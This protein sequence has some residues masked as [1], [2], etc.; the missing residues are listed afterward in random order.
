M[1][2]LQMVDSFADLNARYP[3]WHFWFFGGG[4]IWALISYFVGNTKGHG[5]LGCFL[6]AILGPF[7]LLITALLGR[8]G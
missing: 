2:L 6:G 5:C 1:P 3:H 7:G 4:L 8:K